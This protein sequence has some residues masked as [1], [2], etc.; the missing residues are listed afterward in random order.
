MN[1]SLYEE[2]D[3]CGGCKTWLHCFMLELIIVFSISEAHPAVY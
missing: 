2:A 1:A 3:P